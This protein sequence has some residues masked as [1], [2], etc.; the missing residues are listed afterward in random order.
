MSHPLCK[1]WRMNLASTTIASPKSP[2]F[3]LS[4]HS[5]EAYGLSAAAAWVGH[6]PL[7]ALLFG[8]AAVFCLTLGQKATQRNQ[9]SEG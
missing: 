9:P 2:E 6:L 3:T 1:S 4:K 7:L 8:L 5:F